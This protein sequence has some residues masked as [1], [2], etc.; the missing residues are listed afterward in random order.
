MIL[1]RNTVD[2]RNPTNSVLHVFR[3]LAIGL[4]M[5]ITSCTPKA[6]PV[7]NAVRPTPIPPA[8][9]PAP[10]KELTPGEA[11]W[12]GVIQAARKEE[13]LVLYSFTFA[14][15]MGV[16]VARAFREKYGISVEMVTGPGAQMIERIKT[17]QRSSMFLAD[18]MEGSFSNAMIS[19]QD[20]LTES[21]GEL[22]V[23]QESGIWLISPVAEAS[24]HLLYYSPVLTGPW[25]NTRLVKP[26]ET[27]RSWR[28]FVAPRWGGK[29]VLSDPDI[30]PSPNVMY[31]MLRKYMGFDDAYFVELARQ[32][33]MLVP[34]AWHG[35]MTIARGEAEIQPAGV[36]V[37]Y[38]P[39][40][41]EKPSVRP[42]DM[43]EGLVARAQAVNIVKKAPHPNAARLFFNWILT[44]E[45]QTVQARA[46][47]VLPLRKDVPDFTPEQARITPRKVF[48]TSFE[49]ETEIAKAQR[50]KSLMK[51][52]RQ[53][54]Y[55]K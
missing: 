6:T 30:T 18:I 9:S 11:A 3:A 4:L 44:Q 24:G 1:R 54:G 41:A 23:L 25:I 31:V 26:E 48:V 33:L 12:N 15:D 39:L 20:G 38:A 32:G 36:L 35:P 19:K 2:P 16:A 47:T 13:R 17:E 45:G 55:G 40:L 28:Q 43:D 46:K 49:D 34:T 8:A 51:L 50:E 7:S 10:A 21:Y 14:G 27:P 52:F 29:I 42:I 22:P 53:G 5:A 37:N